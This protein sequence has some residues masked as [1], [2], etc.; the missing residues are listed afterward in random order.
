LERKRAEKMVRGK[1]EA[2]GGVVEKTPG[3][4]KADKE[5]EKYVK[6]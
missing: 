1:V 2:E 6:K 5:R 3:E 4:I